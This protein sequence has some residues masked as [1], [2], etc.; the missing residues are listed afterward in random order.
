ME[1]LRASLK[2]QGQVSPRG[3]EEQ[4]APPIQPEEEV[5]HPAPTPA[6]PVVGEEMDLYESFRQMKASNF[7]ETTDPLLVDNWLIDIHV[8]ME[9][10]G[11]NDKKEVLC[12]S[13]ALKGDARHWR[14]I[15]IARR[16]E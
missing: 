8:I 4:Q 2:Q 3:Q 5:P 16:N 11:L 7:E 9:F 6:A 15:V 12:A 13:F 1:R 10:M 14:R